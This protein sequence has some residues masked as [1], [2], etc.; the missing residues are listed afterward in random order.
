MFISVG[1]TPC[2]S[3]VPQLD[4]DLLSSRISEHSLDLVELENEEKAD[5]DV[6]EER[7]KEEKPQEEYD[8]GK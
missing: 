2:M 8:D 5:D 4:G 3:P 7:N 6:E 1:L